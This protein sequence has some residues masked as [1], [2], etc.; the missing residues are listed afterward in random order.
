VN[1]RPLTS[2]TE[3]DAIQTHWNALSGGVP[4]RRH[5]WLV[6]WARCYLGA[7]KNQT[8]IRRDAVVK[9]LGDGEVCTDH[10]S[11]LCAAE[12]R[13]RVAAALAGFLCDRQD[14]WDRLELADAD[15]GDPSLKLLADELQSRGCDVAWRERGACWAVELPASWVDFLAMQS[16]SHRKQLRKAERR[17]ESLGARWRTV[18]CQ[19]EL[20]V[21]WPILIDLHQRRRAS[22]GEPGCFASQRFS[23][24][25]EQAARDLLRAGRLRLGWLELDGAPAAAELQFVGD[26]ASAEGDAVFA[27]QGGVDPD[28]LD[29][30]PGRLAMIHTIRQ[31]IS[32][33]RSRFDF[34]RGDEPYKPH[35]RATPRPTGTLRA[36]PPRALARLR[37]GADAAADGLRGALKAGFGALGGWQAGAPA[38]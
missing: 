35:W 6:G 31:A 33:G 10:L 17:G 23:Q 5:E 32:E 13:P 25:H 1:V 24:F 29:D 3:L 15:L 11:L 36:A 18:T 34:L 27:Y 20:K 22:L 4:F 14:E 38:K 19:S 16:K 21:A 30:E 8:S 26:V 12:D 7:R 2:L 37:V 9:P 28:R